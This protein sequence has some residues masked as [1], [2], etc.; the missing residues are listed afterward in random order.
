MRA[1]DNRQLPPG[2]AWSA[3]SARSFLAWF[4]DPAGGGAAFDLSDALSITFVP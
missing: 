1:T 4:R 2:G 3:G